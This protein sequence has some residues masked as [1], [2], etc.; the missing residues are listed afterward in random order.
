[1]KRF[2]MHIHLDGYMNEEGDILSKMEQCGIYGGCIISPFPVEYAAENGMCFEDRLDA[3]LSYTADHRDR[4]FPILWI[5]PDEDDLIHKIDV[6]VERGVDGFKIIYNN[7]YIYEERCVS[8][9]KHIASKDKPVIF[10]SGILW[11]GTDSSKYN[12]PLNWE[13][14]I[15]ING[16]RFSMGHCSWPWYDECVA[17]YGKFLNGMTTGETA[18]MFLDITPGTPEIYRED[19]FKK[20]YFCGYDVGDHVLFGCDCTAEAYR[21][22][23]TGKW[24]ETDRTIM[25][26]FRIGQKYREK[27]YYN[28]LM[29]FLGKDK[30]PLDVKSPVPDCAELWFPSE[31]D[32][33]S[34]I[35]K[36]YHELSFP[37]EFD[38]EFYTALKSI[39]V[40]DF[41]CLEAYDLNCTDGKKNLLSFLYFCEQTKKE[42]EFRG[43]GKDV[44]LD[45]LSDIV[46]W[47]KIWSELKGEL[48]LGELSWLKRHLSC[49]LFKLGRLQFCMAIHDGDRYSNGPDFGEEVL[50][51]HVPSTGPLKTNECISSLREALCFFN[52]T[53]PDY[54]FRHFTCDSWLLGQEIDSVLS[55]ESN[56]KRFAT[57]FNV[58]DQKPSESLFRYLFRW[59]ATRE[60]LNH[61]EA[62]SA[63]SVKVKE[64]ALADTVFHNGLGVLKRCEA[65]KL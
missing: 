56:I 65:E 41:D 2:D 49:R 42:Y 43:I 57:L 18:E 64:M 11:D 5:H 60:D 45:T 29:R 48:Y 58:V 27:L 46:I 40:H 44:L 35:E 51:V 31:E 20:L 23:W 38:Q 30:S 26:R 53:F 16:L 22:E 7:F 15:R 59:D 28:N 9:L 19:L 54:R 47:T 13:R 4:L 1:M 14:L 37:R 32:T 24:L 62:N 34:V 36:W 21:P 61:L 50:E 52:K 8:I 3:V 55:T 25:D 10:H 33:A 63:L 6:A 39:K 12:R 17:L